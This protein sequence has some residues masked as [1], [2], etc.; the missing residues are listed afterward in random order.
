MSHARRFLGRLIL[1]AGFFPILANAEP[2]ARLENEFI[3]AG[4]SVGKGV[5]FSKS[6]TAFTTMVMRLIM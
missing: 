1:V 2:I 6:P 5:R 3:E 4:F